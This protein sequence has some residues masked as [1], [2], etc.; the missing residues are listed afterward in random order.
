MANNYFKFKQFTIYQDKCAM[1]VST[2]GCILGA[3]VFHENPKK[4]LDIG[5]GTGM[6][7]LMIAQR[8]P[9]AYIDSLEIDREAVLQSNENIKASPWAE[10]IRVLH[11]RIQDYAE[12]PDGYYDLIVSNP[13]YYLNQ[14]K[15]KNL[16]ENIARHS[17]E[18]NAEDLIT[19][20]YQHLSENGSLFII[21]PEEARKTFEEFVGQ[22]GF[23]PFYILKIHNKPDSNPFRTITGYRKSIDILKE[24]HLVIRD[25]DGSYSI[26]FK[27]LLKDFYLAF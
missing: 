13:P 26:P 2:D 16:K 11:T 20:G 9:M 7:S 4:V 27:A 6:L 1:K 12:R 19:H 14:P 22:I 5:S 15:S 25:P 3:V 23:H 10:R 17:V 24:D 18:L 21:Y 8:Y